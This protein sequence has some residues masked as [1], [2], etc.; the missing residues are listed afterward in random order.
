MIFYFNAL[1]IEINSYDIQNDGNAESDKNVNI[2]HFFSGQT[3][4]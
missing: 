4:I 1:I 2:I 3:G